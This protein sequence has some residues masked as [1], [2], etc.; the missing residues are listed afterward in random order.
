MLAPTVAEVIVAQLVRFRCSTLVMPMSAQ[1][2]RDN[3]A[4]IIGNCALEIIDEVIAGIGKR[5]SGVTRP[6]VAS[7]PLGRHQGRLKWIE[8]TAFLLPVFLLYA[9]DD[10]ACRHLR[11]I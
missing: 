7:V 9:L 1:G 5:G 2:A 4:H 3:R 11:R 10:R 8:H 6:I